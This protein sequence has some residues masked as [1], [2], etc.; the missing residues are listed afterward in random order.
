MPKMMKNR[1]FWDH[2][3]IVLLGLRN[4]NLLNLEITWKDR[5]VGLHSVKAPTILIV[6][7]CDS[8][9]LSG[10]YFYISVILIWSDSQRC[11]IMGIKVSVKGTTKAIILNAWDILSSRFSFPIILCL[12]NVSGTTVT[13]YVCYRIE[14]SAGFVSDTVSN[15]LCTKVLIKTKSNVGQYQ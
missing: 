6:S 1:H 9:S 15:L 14:S 2:L 13:R 8:F 11:D 12:S 7:P 4:S 5:N 3:T 10:I